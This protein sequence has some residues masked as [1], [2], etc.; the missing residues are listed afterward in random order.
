METFFTL[1]IG[2]ILTLGIYTYVKHLQSKKRV[3]SQ[4]VILLDKIKKVCKFITVEGDFAE[5]YH[6]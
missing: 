6:Y 1:I 2:A 4:S 3:S 5:I